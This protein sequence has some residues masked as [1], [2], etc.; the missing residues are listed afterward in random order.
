MRQK[1]TTIFGGVGVAHCFSFL[2][3][4][5]M[6]FTFRVPCCDVR[7]D[8]RIKIMFGSSLLPVV[9]RRTLTYVICVS[10]YIVVSNTYC[11]VFL[12]CIF[13]LLPISLDCPFFIGPSVFFNVYYGCNWTWKIV[14]MRQKSTKTLFYAFSHNFQ[15]FDIL[16]FMLNSIIQ[17][18]LCSIEVIIHVNVCWEFECRSGEK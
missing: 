12:F 5:I 11:A 4:P 2:C 3:F 13:V 9:C 18:L 10:L 17:F 1:S 6:C 15:F 7:N 16:L 14:Q 8:F